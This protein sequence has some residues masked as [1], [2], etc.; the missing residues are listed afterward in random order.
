MELR[1]SF[2]KSFMIELLTVNYFPDN[3]FHIKL[4]G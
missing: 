2:L 3:L 4:R 1:P